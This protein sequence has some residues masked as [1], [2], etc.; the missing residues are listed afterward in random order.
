MP[1]TRIRRVARQANYRG[2]APGAA[3]MKAACVLSGALEEDDEEQAAGPGGPLEG[4]QQGLLAYLALALRSPDARLHL[5]PAAAAQL[6]SPAERSRFFCYHFETF[7]NLVV[8]KVR[9]RL[10]TK[11]TCL[12][13]RAERIAW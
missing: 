1:P 13:P 5:G 8:W 11:P 7:A 4:L 6:A 3:G 9:L 2:A 12:T 10:P